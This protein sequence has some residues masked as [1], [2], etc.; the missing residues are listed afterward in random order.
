[1]DGLD[2]EFA[3]LFRRHS[4]PLTASDLP[5]PARERFA[6]QIQF[7]RSI[8]PTV[9]V[10]V[11]T[12]P[13]FNALASQR[14]GVD[15]I[16]M[17]IG[18]IHQLTLYAY[19]LF[20]DPAVYPEI[21][22]PTAER[23]DDDVIQRLRL[24]EVYAAASL[25]YSPN[26]ATR[27]NAAERVAECACLILF[28]HELG[29]VRGCHLDL[30]NDELWLREYQ[31]INAAPLNDHAALLMRTLELEA[32]SV[33]LA[34]S[35][36]TWRGLTAETG[37]HVVNGLDATCT[38]LLAAE[39]LFW[40]MSLTHDRWRPNQLSSHPSIATRYLNLRFFR[41]RDGQ[42]DVDLVNA[43]DQRN[44]CVIRWMGRHNLSSSLLRW[45]VDD[46]ELATAVVAGEWTQLRQEMEKLWDRLDD[47]Q[48]ARDTR[49]ASRA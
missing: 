22:D 30:L 37:R 18:A 48:R 29:H 13:E 14:N 32:D 27:R 11:L 36:A 33:A 1:M 46:E 44:R 26:D 4:D 3:S 21:G 40:V 19:Q 39:L 47:Y 41:G 31:E 9:Y 49:L 17:Y 42:D 43:W 7:Y 45:S 6:Q 5:S 12:A 8:D 34:N 23:C 16:A 28:F 38:W 35:L 15:F 24:G 2:S 10:G 20:S 25:R